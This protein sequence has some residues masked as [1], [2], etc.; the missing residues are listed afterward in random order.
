MFR[1][2]GSSLSPYIGSYAFNTLSVFLRER[3]FGG[4]WSRERSMMCVLPCIQNE[5]WNVDFDATCWRVRSNSP[6]KSGISSPRVPPRGW[7][8]RWRHHT[9]S[10]VLLNCDFRS[11]QDYRT[12]GFEHWRQDWETMFIHTCSSFHMISEAFWALTLQYKG[13]L[14]R[15]WYVLNATSRQSVCLQDVRKRRTPQRRIPGFF[16]CFFTK[17]KR[18]KYHKAKEINMVSLTSF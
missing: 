11:A 18:R 10:C 3:A 17:Q 13:N 5:L 15:S 12:I 1:T 4:R 6:E 16:S 9:P 7:C 14:S 8:S 2:V